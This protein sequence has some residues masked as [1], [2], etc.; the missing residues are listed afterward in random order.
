MSLAKSKHK[1]ELVKDTPRVSD[2][3]E[4]DECPIFKSD[5][6][7]LQSKFATVVCKLEE[8]KSRLVLLGACKLCPVTT[9]KNSPNKS[10]AKIFQNSFSSLSSFN[11]KP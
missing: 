5:L 11:S 8:M 3:L 1:L 4:C 10:H 6:A 9:R 7:A 2:V